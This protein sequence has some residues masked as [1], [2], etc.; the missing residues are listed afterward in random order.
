M[1]PR[2]IYDKL[3][4]DIQKDSNA[5][6]PVREPPQEHES[7]QDKL[8]RLGK[9]LT[10]WTNSE[11]AATIDD[12]QASTSI[13]APTERN[14][15]FNDNE[16]GTIHTI[17]KDMICGSA[18]ISRVEVDKRCSLS[19]DGRNLLQKSTPL[20]LVNRIKYERRKL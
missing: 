15:S 3:K 19:R 2:R 14:S 1:S 7:M 13:I 17:F 20:A 8:E 18:T 10:N 5:L 11:Q 16:V 12:D 4:K 6:V 9:N